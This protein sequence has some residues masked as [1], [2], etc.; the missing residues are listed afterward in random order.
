MPGGRLSGSS[1]SVRA[2][3]AIQRSITATCAGGTFFSVGGISPSRM[4]STRTLSSGF[5]GTSA[6][7]ALSPAPGGPRQ[8]QVELPL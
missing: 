7:P 5:P 6:G 8:P 4:R 2:P 3:W 1:R